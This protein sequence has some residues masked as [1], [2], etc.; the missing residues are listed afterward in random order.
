MLIV[1]NITKSIQSKAIVKDCS[2]S[3]QAGQ[4]CGLA[5]PNGAGKTTLSQLHRGRVG[6]GSGTD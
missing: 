6:T 5:G 1:D 3:V 4:I 2:L